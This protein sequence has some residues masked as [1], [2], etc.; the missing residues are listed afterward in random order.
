MTHTQQ[1]M[2]N[3]RWMDWAVDRWISMDSSTPEAEMLLRAIFRE[4]RRRILQGEPRRL[5]Q[6]DVL[7]RLDPQLIRNRIWLRARRALRS[8]G[9]HV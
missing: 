7:K 3:E 4:Q 8:K 1:A 5:V 2:A 9:R 6:R